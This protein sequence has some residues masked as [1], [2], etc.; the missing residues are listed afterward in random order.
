[1]SS[2]SACASFPILAFQSL[3]QPEW[4]LW[5][6]VYGVLELFGRSCRHHC[7]HV[8]MLV[9]KPLVMMILKEATVKGIE[10][11]LLETG[12]HPKTALTMS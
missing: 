6:L 2:Q 7:H 11:S 12:R 3:V 10:Y 8:Q 1:M 5:C 4:L 9:H